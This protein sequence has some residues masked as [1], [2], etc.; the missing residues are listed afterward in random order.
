MVEDDLELL[1]EERQKETE[2]KEQALN[3][4][5]QQ[6]EGMN[7]WE[8]I[9]QDPLAA[10][11]S[12]IPGMA[13]GAKSRTNQGT[14]PFSLSDVFTS[15]G[16]LAQETAYF[17]PVV[18]N[19][20]GAPDSYSMLTQGQ[21]LLTKTLG[22]L[23]FLG[24]AAEF[25]GVLAAGVGVA[26]LGKNIGKG[27]PSRTDSLTGNGPHV[28]G[29]TEANTSPT[30]ISKELDGVPL[31][32][33]STERNMLTDLAGAPDTPAKRFTMFALLDSE[34][35]AIQAA[36]K[37]QDQTPGV[38][39][40]AMGYALSGVDAGDGFL[41]F[42]AG[43][44]EM[45]YDRVKMAQN[46]EGMNLD[47]VKA[48]LA[49]SLLSKWNFLTNRNALTLEG[50]F[51][52]ANAVWKKFKETGEIS[53]ADVEKLLPAM[54]AFSEATEDIG[55]PELVLLNDPRLKVHH[56]KLLEQDG[57]PAHKIRLAISQFDELDPTSLSAFEMD[58]RVRL[59]FEHNPEAMTHLSTQNILDFFFSDVLPEYDKWQASMKS[60]TSTRE[61]PGKDWYKLAKADLEQTAIDY[62]VNP[63]LAVGIGALLSA[64]TSWEMNLANVGH[65]LSWVEQHGGKKSLLQKSPDGSYF[66]KTP[67]RKSQ[68]IP[69]SQDLMYLI[70]DQIF[71]KQQSK[72]MY[73]SGDQAESVRALIQHVEDGGTVASWFESQ[74]TKGGSLKVPN[75]WGA[76]AK[77][78]DIDNQTR[79]VIMHEI[80][81]GNVTLQDIGRKISSESKIGLELSKAFKTFPLTIDRHAYAAAMGY[82]TMPHTDATIKVAYDPIKLAYIAAAE[83]IGEVKMSGGKKGIAAKDVGLLDPNE[84]Q[85]LIWLAWREKRGV[86]KNFVEVSNPPAL[87]ANGVG[88]TYVQTPR[89]LDFVAGQ[90]PDGVDLG[91]PRI[92]GTGATAPF[93]QFGRTKGTGVETKQGVLKGTRTGHHISYIEIGPDGPVHVSSNPNDGP[94]QFTFPSQA[95]DENGHTIHMARSPMAVSDVSDHLRSLGEQTYIDGPSGRTAA[96]TGGRFYPSGA[97]VPGLNMASQGATGLHAKG[98]HIVMSIPNTA[99]KNVT[100]NISNPAG[101]AMGKKAIYSTVSTIKEHL[102]GKFEVEP[103][104]IINTP[105]T[106]KTTVFRHPDIL[107]QNGKPMDFWTYDAAEQYIQDNNLPYNPLDTQKIPDMVAEPRQEVILSFNTGEDMRNAHAVITSNLGALKT[108]SFDGVNSPYVSQATNHYITTQKKTL[109]G[110]A[111]NLKGVRLLRSR[112]TGEPADLEL[113]STTMERVADHYDD[114][115]VYSKQELEAAAAG[116]STAVTFRSGKKPSKGA[117]KRLS[118][119]RA[120]EDEIRTQYIYLTE[121]MGIKVELVDTDP[122]KSPL[123]M[124]TDVKNNNTI[125]ILST[126]STGSHPYFPD[127]INDMLRAIHDV[128]GHASEG[129]NFSRHGEFMAVAK[130]AQ[131][132]SEEALP[133]VMFDL[134]GQTASLA[135]S[136][137]FPPQKIGILPKEFWPDSPRWHVKSMT[138][139]DKIASKTISKGPYAAKPDRHRVID[140]GHNEDV[141]DYRVIAPDQELPDGLVRVKEHYFVDGSG[142][143]LVHNSKQGDRTAQNTREVGILGGDLDMESYMEGTTASYT[144]GDATSPSTKIGQKGTT[145]KQRRASRGE[146]GVEALVAGNTQYFGAP[147]IQGSAVRMIPI[148]ALEEIADFSWNRSRRP[149][150]EQAKMVASIKKDGLTNPIRIMVSTDDFASG[151]SAGGNL[152]AIVAN[153]NHRLAAAREAGLTHVPVIGQFDANHDLARKIKQGPLQGETGPAPLTKNVTHDG[154]VDLHEQFEYREQY[155]TSHYFDVW[156]ILDVED[157]AVKASARKPQKKI[158]SDKELA[159]DVHK[160]DEAK[161]YHGEDAWVPHSTLTNG[162]MGQTWG[163]KILIRGNVRVSQKPSTAGSITEPGHIFGV[164]VATDKFKSG[165]KKGQLKYDKPD[166][167]VMYVPE[168]PTEMPVIM[169]N[170][171]SISGLPLERQVTLQI[172]KA[173]KKGAMEPKLQKDPVIANLVMKPLS[174]KGQDKRTKLSKTADIALVTR[175][176]ETLKSSG[177]V[178]GEITV[179]VAD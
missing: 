66:Y 26:G 155:D 91:G 30:W 10:A 154:K 82:S 159:D 136:G 4:A 72:K 120:F 131:M 88:P 49:G 16:P 177:L 143:I 140:F 74:M 121:T 98:F 102:N 14:D 134:L 65:I 47:Q 80:L 118:A 90:L 50:P 93:E 128:F 163:D 126:K 101:S 179:G 81:L 94:N 160:L 130:H 63:E 34:S 69:E 158:L 86:T 142:E 25:G 178:F 54:K 9:K 103:E 64:T 113:N 157:G 2:Q 92:N 112:R 51:Q 23:G 115:K 127:E 176:R 106:G 168:D 137:K 58:Q 8:T 135:R 166:S 15:L 129:T 119:W 165:P 87:H 5:S 79:R 27:I 28:Q 85:A 138:K 156:T 75:F 59:M 122:Y 153:G 109:S 6:D 44:G 29:F 67:K 20:V 53:P 124:I 21:G 3:T 145:Q 132:F 32:V 114:T 111:L 13:S 99:K 83:V 61:G 55:H 147:E 36:V 78:S 105:H 172:G 117:L 125:K 174:T 169:Y 123:E 116:S 42:A 24:G 170:E 40:E 162:A 110:R 11:V 146:Q 133:A 139:K 37:S 52:Q 149:D 46:I 17:L 38:R 175:A 48:A 33:S 141:V 22:A 104:F 151:Q 97:F 1:D 68:K 171:S 70:N 12:M 31:I 76:I 161:H 43:L 62:N 108:N 73:M 18:G 173:K 60:A 35:Q 150:A 95:T 57:L 152:Q 100:Q 7:V 56:V 167:I 19:V 39:Y 107:D 164:E 45:L 84:L 71:G 144:A 148:E 89:V 41:A 77:S 96:S